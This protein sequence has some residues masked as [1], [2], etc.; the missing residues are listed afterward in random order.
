MERNIKSKLLKSMG[1]IFDKSKGSKFNGQLLVDIEGDLQV[2]SDYFSCTKSQSFIISHVFALNYKGDTVDIKDLVEH[3]ECNPLL[4]LEYS[5]DFQELYTK[6]ILRRERSRHRPEVFLTNDQFTVDKRITE[7]ILNNQ[8]FPEP[9][10]Q[11]AETI[12]D[13]LELIDALVSRKQG[14]GIAQRLMLFK[15]RSILAANK[16]F[17]LLKRLDSFDLSLQDQFLFLNVLWKTLQGA[18]AVELSSAIDSVFDRSSQKINYIQSILTASNNLISNNLLEVMESSFYGET[19]IT[20]ANFGIQMLKE[21]GVTLYKKK[22]QNGNIILPADINSKALFFNKKEEELLKMLYDILD[23]ENLKQVQSRMKAKML[24]S[25]VTVLL[26]GEPGTGKTETV[27]QLARST[28]REIFM[29]DISQTKS[30]WYGESQKIIRRLFTDYSEYTQK[31]VKTPIFLLNEADAVITKR[32]DTNS[33]GVAQTEN[34]IQN[35][36]LEELENFKGIF[37]ATTNLI[38]NIDPAFDRRFLFKIEFGKPNA[39]AKAKIWQS[40]LPALSLGQCELLAE[41][42]DFSGGQIDNIVRKSE[43][44]EIINGVP[45]SIEQVINFCSAEQLIGGPTKKIG[46][47]K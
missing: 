42:F 23:N 45:V 6:G 8:P 11:E 1:S 7:A 15:L 14:E 44:H 30:F 33:S 41:R 26:H 16:H 29:V 28:D 10:K 17:A 43:M 27:Y 25:G 38:Q 37:V 18:N 21:E 5:S 19:E 35:I 20:I 40:K 13:V 32:K 12:L 46:Y 34:A 24:P 39:I 47:G 22:I 31:C 3:I 2:V 9:E 36:I 4:L